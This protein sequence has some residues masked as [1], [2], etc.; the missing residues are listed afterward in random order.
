VVLG[1]NLPS[2][3][4]N[5]GTTLQR[6]TT[7]SGAVSISDGSLVVDGSKPLSISIP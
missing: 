3:T 1:G 6:T 5:G 4:I 7:A 2:V